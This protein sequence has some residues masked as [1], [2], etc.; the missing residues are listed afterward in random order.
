M[1]GTESDA[2]L[3]LK[4]RLEGMEQFQ[5]RGSCETVKE[6]VCWAV[7]GKGPIGTRWI[8][9]DKSNVDNPEYRSRLVAQQFK[10]KSK[11]NDIFAAT[12]PLEA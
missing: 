11:E 2:H 5:K 3:A 9:V 1:S 6:E 7:A 12:P 4:A 10:R 8:D